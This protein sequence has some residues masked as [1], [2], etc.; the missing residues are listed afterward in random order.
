MI[1]RFQDENILL[2]SKQPEENVPLFDIADINKMGSGQIRT[3][4]E[5][6]PV[7]DSQ[8]EVHI[9]SGD[10]L[11]QSTII[12][13]PTEKIV[14]GERFL[15]LRPEYDV[16]TSGIDRGYYSIVYNF[17]TKLTTNSLKIERISGDGT[18]IELS[19]DT[20]GDFT[21][22]NASEQ[23]TD[24]F[25]GPNTTAKN[26][27]L[28]FGGNDLALITDVSFQSNIAERIGEKIVNVPFPTG[29]FTGTISFKSVIKDTNGNVV[30]QPDDN[31]TS[32][33]IEVEN[34]NTTFFPSIIDFRDDR[35]FYIEC[36][37][38]S[39]N[40][41][42]SIRDDDN[43]ILEIKGLRPTG[44]VAKFI[45]TVTT[46]GSTKTVV[47]VQ[48]TDLNGDPIFYTKDSDKLDRFFEITAGS[49]YQGPFISPDDKNVI[50]R[51]FDDT[52]KV[53]ELKKVVV[54]LYK[55]LNPALESKFCSIDLLNNDSYI[56]RL[57]VYPFNEP[58]TIGDF[59]PP[60]FDIKT[61][62]YGKSQGT[63]LK[64]FNQLLDANLTTSQQI[65][66]KYISSSFGEVDVNVNYNELPNFVHY[67]SATERVKNF[68]YK[69]QLIEGFDARISTLESVS[70]SHALTN[71]S[72]SLTRKNGVISGFD[73]FEKFL[74]YE[75]TGSLYTHYS[76]SEYIVNPW[77]KQTVY[78]LKLEP[79]TSSTAINYYNSLIDTCTTYDVLNDARLTK[80]IP[81]SVANDDLNSD[82]LL[83]IDMIGHHFDITWAYIKKLTS[84]N[85]REEHPHDGIPNELLYN[86][87]KSAGWKLTHGKQASDL[88]KYALGTDQ[89][90][91]PIQSGS[92][93]SKSDE[94][95]N[96]EVW[97]RIVNN[98]PYLLKTKGTARAVKALMATYGIPQSFLNIKEFGGPVIEPDE[99]VAKPIYEHDEFVYNL[100]MDATTNHISIPW[101]KINDLN[102]NTYV[103]NTANPIDTIELQFK[104]ELTGDKH[105]LLSK[106]GSTSNAVD[107]LVLLQPESAV[108]ENG[109]V[110]LFLSGS[111]GYKS[112][113]ISDVPI[114]DNK[115]SS[116]FL[117]R[118]T[119]VNDINQ[120]NSY[121]LH[122]R[123]ARNGEIAFRK[124]ASISITG[125]ATSSFNPAW[126][127]SGTFFVGNGGIPTEGVP[128][129][130]NSSK[131]I[132][133]SV[134]E[135]RYYTDP[136]NDTVMD[137]HTLS[138]ESYH[139]NSPTAS[140]FDLKYRF[141]P[142]KELKTITN[143]DNLA[144]KHPNQN[145]TTTSVGATLSASIFNVSSTNLVGVTDT[146]HTKVPSAGP[147]NIANNKVRIESSNLSGILDPDQ[148]KE[149][150][151]YDTAPV[152]S[153]KLG[154]FLSATSVYN[155]D[156]FN[157]TGFFNIDDYVG[158]PDIRKGFDDTNVELEHLRRQVFKKYSS[159]NLIN[160]IIDILA[161]FD[162]TVFQQIKQVLPA[163][164]DY[165]YGILIEPHILERPKASGNVG[166]SRTRPQHNTTLRILGKETNMT[167]SYVT[168]QGQISS[169]Q[170][171]VITASRKD[172]DSI[173]SSSLTPQYNPAVYKYTLLN[174]S[175]GSNVG[176]GVNWTT[177]SNGPWN[178]NPLGVSITG[179]KLALHAKVENFFYSSSLSA[180]LNKPYSS[181][182]TQAQ[183]STDGQSI[184]LNNLKFNGCKVSS[185]S[186][187][188]N[189]PDTPD[190]LPVVEVFNADP[191]VLVVTTP[192]SNLG[193]LKIDTSTNI[194]LLSTD[195]L[196]VD[197]KILF[198][199]QIT[200]NN[201]NSTFYTDLQN[202]IQF[203]DERREEFDNKF[204]LFKDD[205][206][207]EDERR[208][209]FDETNT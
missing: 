126:T 50:I 16:R 13:S 9:Y 148:K 19:T 198:N 62:N 129:L 27:V 87:A 204:N 110:H 192:T 97:R 68:K 6:L 155:D 95:I 55:P 115:M 105:V 61:G 186:L 11:I 107:F 200:V 152:D 25:G 8:Q 15:E 49:L 184:T 65:I 159:K 108:S 45:P 75:S 158:N 191:N 205:E 142:S 134:Q 39:N 21:R 47:L 94:Q 100:K 153:N 57:L 80:L 59:S 36:T 12:T 201:L 149:K 84:L 81:V 143:P 120:N 164:V 48:E 112:S 163:R 161:R 73:G 135:I 136:L 26:Y 165:D 31:Q 28:N 78:P 162:F 190:G 181:S 141:L 119:S 174:Y 104:H 92:L 101:G 85:T 10:N 3:D 72:Q 54:K 206:L 203:E 67:S 66:D 79:S 178:F 125:D 38:F 102:P 89:N 137:D 122:Y 23:L 130:W 30:F 64:N 124:S 207:L 138:R 167:S 182:F 114:F 117:K 42:P 176:F 52:L 51:F 180:S 179:S 99:M 183:S 98:L 150:S 131:Y 76:S 169:S 82:Y 133:G 86:V 121:T 194:P 157:H 18:E 188:T 33:D 5:V 74:Y 193:N 177:G 37:D 209:L 106:S 146:Y 196:V 116:L 22:L 202:M 171:Y 109:T 154:I 17:L 156:V 46:V 166:I 56:E 103:L 41:G 199:N 111:G 70:G 91:N 53:P 208:D 127:G 63:D 20:A 118:D 140:Y 34:Q 128:S 175:Q 69:L 189:S 88:W 132:N 71:I 60:N 160:S 58:V 44:R 185:D 24:L 172:I 93:A 173:G 32:I 1:D 197:D 170:I 144:S 29:S 187:T 113:S 2:N 147:N 77:P 151:R 139:G 168:Y 83:F 40:G 43:N 14:D 90:G 4:Y 35:Q 195:G 96:N 123:R 7:N 145:I